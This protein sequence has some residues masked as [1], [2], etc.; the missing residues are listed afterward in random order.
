M[1]Q[2]TGREFC[3]FLQADPIGFVGGDVNIYRYVGN[4]P[5]NLI[6]PLGLDPQATLTRDPAPPNGNPRNMQEH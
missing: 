2:P 5:I 6:D 3:P 1:R 4:N